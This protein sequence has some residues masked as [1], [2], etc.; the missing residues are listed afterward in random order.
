MGEQFHL[1]N[2]TIITLHKKHNLKRYMEHVLKWERCLNVNSTSSQ[3]KIKN[4]KYEMC[5][6]AT[7]HSKNLKKHVVIVHD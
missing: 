6:Y 3:D 7:G 2:K 5:S 4:F 1:C